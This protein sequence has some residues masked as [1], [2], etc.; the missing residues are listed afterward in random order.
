M[1]TDRPHP[2]QRRRLGRHGAALVLLIAAGTGAFAQAAQ[3]AVVFPDVTVSRRHGLD[4]GTDLR[5]RD[6][7][8]MLD[9]FYSGDFG[10]WR[11]LGEVSLSEDERE[12]ERLQ[13][14]WLLDADNT[15]WLGRFHNPLGYWNTQFHHGTYL[16][17]S[18]SRPGIH[19]HEHED[20]ALPTHL[21]GALWEGA[22]ARDGAEWRYAAA[23]GAGPELHGTL[24][25]VN[26]FSPG[27]GRH[28]L[29]ATARLAYAPRAH[30]AD[31]AGLF[32]GSA[33]LPGDGNPFTEVRQTVSGAYANWK[34]GELRVLGEA[35]FVH[36][37]LEQSGG[38]SA[39]SF[40]SGYLQLEYLL[41]QSWTP[42]GRAEGSAGARDDAYLARF[43]LFVQRRELV[44]L[45]YE[46]TRRQA[47]KFE[48]SEAHLLADSYRQAT[49][50]WSAV[51]P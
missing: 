18:I 2:C 6:I 15:L 39:A 32:I 11:V 30:D 23:L 51:F 12:I 5:R 45:R 3:D 29:S 36:N 50:Q 34:L 35:F 48:L 46:L 41:G 9:L 16:Q 19:E 37:R 49:L 24:D 10:R 14:G 47:L 27:A 4:P 44:G 13:L 28:R 26:I 38:R 40:A 33:R 20:G 42:Y 25:P 17:T 1:R 43:P 8:P 7:E 31:E 21:A 22:Y